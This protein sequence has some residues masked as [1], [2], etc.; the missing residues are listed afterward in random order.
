MRGLEDEHLLSTCDIT[1]ST[2]TR[3][4]GHLT[5]LITAWW[6]ECYYSHIAARTT[7]AQNT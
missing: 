6:A 4:T 1:H 7:N 2:I 3:Y 5:I